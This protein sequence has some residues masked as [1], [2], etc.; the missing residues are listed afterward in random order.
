MR[1]VIGKRVQTHL[2]WND[3]TFL[4]WTP[5]EHFTWGD[6]IKPSESLNINQTSSL[7]L[8]V[9][10]DIVLHLLS[11]F[12][13]SFLTLLSDGLTHLHHP[14][15]LHHL[16]QAAVSQTWV[17]AVAF[18]SFSFALPPPLHLLSILPPP[19]HLSSFHPPPQFSSSQMYFLT[20]RF[21]NTKSWPC[22]WSETLR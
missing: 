9:L 19:S 15:H 2:K 8:S 14:F 7:S 4:C 1:F 18:H 10:S 11:F 21:L 3:Q 17:H 20:W 22:V 12:F 5:V 16:R 6:W 13:S